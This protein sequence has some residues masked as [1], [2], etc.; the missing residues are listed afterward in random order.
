MDEMR[1]SSY[2]KTITPKG[3][4]RYVLLLLCVG[5]LEPSVMTLPPYSDP[6]V[7]SDPPVDVRLGM[8]AGITVSPI[9]ISKT[10]GK[11][12]TDDEEN[13][14][15]PPPSSTDSRL[16]WRSTWEAFWFDPA[17][18]LFPLPSSWEPSSLLPT[19]DCL[20]TILCWPWACSM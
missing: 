6:V 11:E 18:R 13:G 8:V 1:R 12:S 9:L 17:P 3:I 5:N 20:V 14:S 2:Q 4:T 10:L 16:D 19:D 15:P 7:M